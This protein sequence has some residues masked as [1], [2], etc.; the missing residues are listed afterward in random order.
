LIVVVGPPVVVP[1]AIVTIFAVVVG[2]NASKSIP[3]K[4]KGVEVVVDD[5]VAVAFGSTTVVT[6]GAVGTSDVLVVVEVVVVD[7]VV[8]DVVV[9]DVV[10]VVAGTRSGWLTT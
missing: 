7:V 4:S 10:V 2:A 3:E 9:V 6:S 5:D 1:G 8:V